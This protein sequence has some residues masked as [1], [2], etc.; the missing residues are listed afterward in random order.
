MNLTNRV[1]GL[2][3][4]RVSLVLPPQTRPSPPAGRQPTPGPSAPDDDD[5]IDIAC[6]TRVERPGGA[7]LHV[8]VKWREDGKWVYL[9]VEIPETPLAGEQAGCPNAN[10]SEST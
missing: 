5:G 6:V 7:V 4:G 2:L 10:R 9:G 1:T 3:G 8:V